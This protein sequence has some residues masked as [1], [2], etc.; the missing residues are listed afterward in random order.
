MLLADVSVNV[1]LHHDIYT[2]LERE[3]MRGK[4][5]KEI[6]LNTLP[7]TRMEVVRALRQLYPEPS[8]VENMNPVWTRYTQAFKQEV[9]KYREE[10]LLGASYTYIDK[11]SI[12]REDFRYTYY[13]LGG[14]QDSLPFYYQ[15]GKDLEK[16][17]NLFVSLDSWMEY[18]H[19]WAGVYSEILAS[20][21][22]GDE[23]LSL[24]KAYAKFGGGNFEVT[25][26]KDT[27]WW[28][29]GQ[30][31]TLILSDNAE[32]FPFIQIGGQHPGSLFGLTDA[33]GTW[34]W[35]IFVGQLEHDRAMPQTNLIGT[36]LTW[37]PSDWLEFGAAKIT[38][39]G[40]E[41]QP[42]IRNARDIANL[43][44]FADEDDGSTRKSPNYNHLAGADIA[45]YM[46]WFKCSFLEL[47]GAKVFTEYM[48]EDGT[49]ATFLGIQHKTPASISSIFG[50]VASFAWGD[51]RVEMTT[52]HREAYIHHH[53]KSGYTYKDHRLA[54]FLP[55]DS[56][57]IAYALNLYPAPSWTVDLSY[58][59]SRTGISLRQSRSRTRRGE[60]AGTR[61]FDD[62]NMAL[63]FL[64]GV[65]RTTRIIE[66]VSNNTYDNYFGMLSIN[67]YFGP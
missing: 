2:L 9:E 57:E 6:H 8:D 48:G 13:Q 54:S 35:N 16:G 21:Q 46:P 23:D 26:G 4:L 43:F 15:Q 33:L 19:G 67:L 12:R 45:L 50:G 24:K 53:Y 18:E 1:P 51:F 63:E 61:F 49:K 17:G 5:G 55:N 59:S 58:R 42:A 47:E 41:G 20:V 64:F 65:D 40:G 66:N 38:M 34:D 60:I 25:L 30:L 52:L 11:P 62:P 31:Q 32:A 37:A 27:R 28:G 39:F 29:S 22:G 56:H 10:T 14:G 44:L 3:K 36:R 7:L